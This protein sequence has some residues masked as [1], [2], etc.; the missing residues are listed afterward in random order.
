MDKYKKVVEASSWERLTIEESGSCSDEWGHASKSLIRFS[1]DGWGCVPSLLFGLRPNYGRGNNSNDD[2]LQKD[3]RS[4]CCIQCPW[5]LS[6]LL[7]THTS[8]GDCWTLTG[9]SDSVSCGNTAPFSWLLVHTRFYLCSPRAC[10]PSPVEVL[11]SNPTGLQ[12]QISWGFSVPLLDTQVE[13]SVVGPRTFLINSVRIVG[14]IVLQFVGCLLDSFMVELMATSSKSANATCYMSQI[15][16]IQSPCTHS[17]PVL[18]WASP[19]DAQTLKGRFNSVSVR[20]LGPSAHKALFEP[21]KHLCQVW[22]LILN[23]ISPLQLSSP[24]PWMWGIFFWRDPTFSCWWLFSSDLQFWSSCRKRRVRVLLSW[25]RFKGLDLI[26]R[27]PEELRTEVP[28]TVQK[29]VI[30]TTILPFCIYFSCLKRP[31]K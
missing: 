14:T 10:F 20:F 28:N 7:L 24:L 22:G 30:K 12:N 19:G 11:S 2:L 17:K 21:S 1:I 23:V 18:T 27:V 16:C 25:Q 3:L 9:K 13:K 4:H 8:A 29:A 5:L 26:D 31:Y 6:R 15:C